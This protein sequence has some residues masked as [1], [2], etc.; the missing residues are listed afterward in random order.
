MR[1]MSCIIGLSRSGLCEEMD[2][3]LSR[4]PL[5]HSGAPSTFAGFYLGC[6]QDA[7]NITNA[8]MS[9]GAGGVYLLSPG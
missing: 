6:I 5:L 4:L 3:P 9:A 8:D 1:T 7:S 2:R